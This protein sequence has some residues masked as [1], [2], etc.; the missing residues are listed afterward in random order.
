MNEDG[1]KGAWTKE[2]MV[3]QPADF[4]PRNSEWLLNNLQLKTEKKN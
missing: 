1:W 4:V 3:D 2:T